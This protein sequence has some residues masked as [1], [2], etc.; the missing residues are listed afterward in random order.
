MILLTATTQTLELTTSSTA[1]TDVYVAYVEMTSSVFTPGQQNANITTATTTTILAAPSGASTY[2][3]VK[4][5][6]VRNKSTTASQTVTLLH[7][8]SGTERALSAA[9]TL[10]AGEVLEYNDGTGFILRTASGQEKQAATDTV[11]QSGLALEL[12]KVGT[13]TEAAGVRYCFNKDSGSPG[14]WVPGAPGLNGWWTDASTATNAANPAGATQC[15]CWQLA[16]PASGGYYLNQ[17][18]VA[19]SVASQIEIF[20]LVWYNTGLVVTTTTA[21]TVTMPGASI[22]AR[23]ANGTTNGENWQAGI[24]VTTATTNAGAVTNTTLS[25]TNSEG[26]AG[27]TATMASFPATA[28]IGTFVPF[29]LQAGDR[30]IRSIQSVTL[31][32]SY[33]A[34][35]ISVL[36]YR[37][38]TC[39]PNP[40]AN[41]G[42]IMNKLS[43]DPTGTRVY[44]GSALCVRYLPSATTATTISGSIRLSNR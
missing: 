26:T 4:F 16:N 7:D 29:Q 23:D 19:A 6:S 21:Q 10:A 18:G 14:A 43:D 15:G 42:G 30:G 37:T 38:I 5:L 31:G 40:L 24:Y 11:G 35:A 8:T 39:I 44:N 2:R 9:I 13:A 36:L 32:T 27:R 22:P 17:A 1:S 12:L 28:V 3:Q 20:D 25:Y 34:G 33:V 41:V